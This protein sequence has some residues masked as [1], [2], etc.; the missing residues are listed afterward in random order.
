MNSK[1]LTKIMLNIVMVILYI[2]LI[3]AYETGLAYHEIVGLSIFA[4]FSI[5][6]LLN[7]AWIKNLTRNLFNPKLKTS[8]KLK[9]ALNMSLFLCIATVTVTGVLLSQ[10]VFPSL[11]TSFSNAT[12]IFV[13]KWLSYLCLGLFGLHIALHGRYLLESFR[14]ISANLRES[15]VR[16]TILQLGATALIV[17]IVYSRV[18][19]T[20]QGAED[21]QATI[22]ATKNASVAQATT[23]TN[24]D[25]SSSNTE[26]N[27]N[28]S[29]ANNVSS[30]IST[31]ETNDTSTDPPMTLTEYLSGLHCTACHKNC[32]LARPQCGK[33]DPE[34][35]EAK[36]EYQELYGTTAS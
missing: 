31:V 2:S 15:N 14:K 33:A 7:G 16:R 21:I 30:S 18:I 13:H 17:G 27:V 1:I 19:T 24:S 28:T 6:C 3:Y 12:L 9:Y 34:I 25:L 10:V 23:V 32:T 26:V 8:V 29:Y 20:V 36:A 11:G 22:Y 35:R 5:H 4:L